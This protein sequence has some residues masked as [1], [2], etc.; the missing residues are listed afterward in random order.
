MIDQIRTDN[1][2]RASIELA[3]VGMLG[4]KEMLYPFNYNHFVKFYFYLLSIIFFLN[5][6]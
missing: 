2:S 6:F 1:Y 3:L 5:D 4:M